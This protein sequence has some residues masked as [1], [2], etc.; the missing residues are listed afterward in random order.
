[1]I[2]SA[3]IACGLLT[4]FVQAAV[5]QQDAHL[6]EC[7]DLSRAEFIAEPWEENTATYA[8]GAVRIA[9]LDAVEPAAAA[10]R[11]LILSPPND[12]VGM[13][14]CRMV[15]PSDGNGYAAIDF[16][17]RDSSYDAA[18]G[19]TVTIPVQWYSDVEGDDGRHLLQITINQGTGEITTQGLR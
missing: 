6:R 18:K 12:E 15:E 8:K 13:P 5:A 7:D 16:A 4:L 19:L 1:M 14:Q 11:L 17:G 9:V 3:S 10:F 2:R